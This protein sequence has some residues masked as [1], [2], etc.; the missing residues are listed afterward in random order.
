[1][2]DTGGK[3]PD[4]FHFLR[5]A[6]LLFEFLPFLLCPPLLGDIVDRQ[7]YQSDTG[8]LL[9]IDPSGVQ[10]HDLAADRGK[11]VL[12]LEVLEVPIAPQDF[13]QQLPQ[14]GNVPLAL[15]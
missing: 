3:C 13:L 12:H 5:L 6:K 1:M 2:G 11:V 4:T 7:E 14:A 8:P 10:G 15:P 9:I